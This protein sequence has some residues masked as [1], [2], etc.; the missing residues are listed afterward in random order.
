MKGAHLMTNPGISNDK[1]DGEVDKN[2]TRM[3][4]DYLF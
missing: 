3:K 2:E 1:E 4:I